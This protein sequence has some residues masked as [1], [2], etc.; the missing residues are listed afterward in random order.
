MAYSA[1]LR[2]R[3]LAFVQGGGSKTEAA[4]RFGMSRAI[5][6]LWCKTPKKLRAEKP[7]PKGC[8]KLNFWRWSSKIDRFANQG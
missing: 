5:V 1:D 6:F 3:V 4:E 7:G 2:K 8:W